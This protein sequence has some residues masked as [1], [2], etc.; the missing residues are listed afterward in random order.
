MSA[1]LDRL[2]TALAAHECQPTD[3]GVAHCPAHDDGTASLSFKQGDKGVLV[4]CFAG[5]TAAAITEALG[6]RMSDLFDENGNGQ[7]REVATYDYTDEDGTLLFQVVRF[8]PKGFRQRRPNGHGGWVWKLGNT[9]RVLYRLPLVIEAV[10]AG[11]TVYVVEGEKDVATLVGWGLDATCNPMGAGKWRAEYSEALRGAH[12][13]IIPDADIEGRRHAASV[14]ASLSGVAAEVRKV[15][16][17]A[18]KDATAWRDSHGG[19]REALEALVANPPPAVPVEQRE[20]EPRKTIYGEYNGRLVHNTTTRQGAPIAVPLA[21]FTAR[22]EAITQRDDGSD[23][24]P[25]RHFTIV[26]KVD[27]GK[28]LPSLTVPALQYSGMNWVSAGWGGEGH[29]FAGQGTRDHLRVAIEE[30]SGAITPTTTYTHLGF[31]NVNGELVYLHAGGAIG[32]GGVVPDVHV[33]PPSD[34]TAYRLPPPP[35]GEALREAV[36]TAMMGFLEVAPDPIS[37]P[38]LA[39]VVRAPLCHIAPPANSMHLVGPT[40]AGKTT[41]TA[42]AASFYGC[43]PRPLHLAASWQSTANAIGRLGHA[44]KDVLLPID[45]YA[46]ATNQRDAARQASD[47][48]NVFRSAGNQQG[49]QRLRSDISFNTTYIVRGFIISTGEDTP[50]GQSLR[51]RLLTIE[52]EPTSLDWAAVT[53]AQEPSQAATRALAMSGYIRWLIKNLDVLKRGLPGELKKRRDTNEEGDTHRR[54]VDSVAVLAW[55]WGAWLTFARE[56]GAICESEAADLQT[57]ATTALNELAA[58]QAKHITAADPVTR[59]WELLSALLASGRAHV[60]RAGSGDTPRN[61]QRWGW[62]REEIST[63]EGPE[64]RWRAGGQLI[65]WVATRQ[66][67]PGDDDGGVSAGSIE[68]LLN[69]EMAFSEIQKLARDQGDHLSISP[70][71]LWKRLDERGELLLKE[72]PR[73]TC[74]RTVITGSPRQR[75][76]LLDATRLGAGEK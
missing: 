65:G 37:I 17:P 75:V 39:A 67:E 63:R 16:L 23:A 48:A 57:R 13:V 40:H 14:A 59:F 18:G 30:V 55:A 19:T 74:R 3:R 29:I 45:D 52:M 68:L 73:Y 62:K 50:F 5:C 66:R 1:A 9:R 42:L 46:P 47:A 61:A 8:A 64:E 43:D 69:P 54:V 4:K 36:R 26:G 34:L 71:T 53:E 2:R 41:I 76:L 24:E 7:R 35:E 56:V 49:R 27:T 51:A 6:L 33:D 10:K 25:I 60:A 21:N 72:P 70:Q 38:I 15:E 31:R 44:A 28:V 22:I 11:R 12:V 32:A 58:G 20:D